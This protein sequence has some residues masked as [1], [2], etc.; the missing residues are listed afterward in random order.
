MA[1]QKLEWKDVKSFIRRR[2][3]SFII[4]FL[5]TFISFVI[6]ALA[7]PSIYRGE[8]TILIEDR[9]IPENL[10]QSTITSY[11]EERLNVIQRQVLSN[12]RLR[13]I[14]EEFD[15]YPDIREAEGMGAAIGAMKEAIGLEPEST[16]F[17]DP[18]TG[19]PMSVTIAF[20]LSYAGRDP[21]TVQKVTN[22]LGRLFLE[23]ETRIKERITGAT[24]DFLMAEAEALKARIQEHEQKITAFKSAHFG[25][26]PEHNKVNLDAVARLERELDQIDMQIRSLQEQKIS[27]QGQRMSVDPLM[28]VQVDGQNVARNPSEQLKSLRLKL[29]SL[30]SVLSDK[31]PDVKKLKREIEKL[32]GQVGASGVSGE[33]IK[34]LDDLRVRLAGL[35]SRY[36]ARHPDVVKLEKEI[37]I[38]ER[39]IAGQRR[40][41]DTRRMAREVPDNPLYISLTTQIASIDASIAGLVSDKASVRNDLA[42]YRQ[43]IE[44]APMVEK[45]YG[46][47]TR[48]YTI[49]K[50][51]Y[52]EIMNK[53]MTAKV[54]QGM[55]EGQHGQ[56]FEIKSQAYLP[57]KPYKP[58]RIAI[59]LLGFVL[60]SSFAFGVAAVR[61]FF[62]H[63]VKNDKE[64]SELVS[65][66]VLTVISNVQ[67]RQERV[68]GMLR[69][70]AWAFAVF[71]VVLIGAKVLD[72][73]VPIREI[74][75]SMILNAKNM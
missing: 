27:L 53:L 9:Q 64:L 13:D 11:A 26:L 22:V 4:A 60:A 62:D 6:L 52:D 48:D 18:K 10:V 17:M 40:S 29:I 69:G 8:T 34:R 66:P 31:H 72:E 30:Q 41:G 47:L 71:A 73:F 61:E 12:D 59:M 5:I 70:L 43:R 67:T 15:L 75:D 32:E 2:R 33:E 57:T 24:T 21:E 56:R 44:T 16:A 3:R 1:D 49:T 51:K 37:D 23:E 25:E 28:P 38:L 7:L 50:E 45:E 36:G 20:L 46:E 42:R 35:K 68:K 65:V 63:S 74:W 39:S 58:N 19:K 54:A 14:I 55:E